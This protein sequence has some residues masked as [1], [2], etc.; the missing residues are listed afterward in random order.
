MFL[1]NRLIALVRVW[2]QEPFIL[3]SMLLT[4][5]IRTVTGLGNVATA[6][7]SRSENMIK[8]T[9]PQIAA[10][11]EPWWRLSRLDP[12]QKHLGL[13]TMRCQWPTRPR[14]RVLACPCFILLGCVMTFGNKRKLNRKASFGPKKKNGPKLLIK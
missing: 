8:A 7:G 12:L 10:P 6:K 3:C 9:R 5:K 1:A 11:P 2:W 4:L 13:K 14:V